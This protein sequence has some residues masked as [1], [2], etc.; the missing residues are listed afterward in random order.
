MK[1][2]W[3]VARGGKG[4]RRRRRV[5]GIEVKVEEKVEGGAVQQQQQ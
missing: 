5:E 3:V 2:D 1:R 4:R